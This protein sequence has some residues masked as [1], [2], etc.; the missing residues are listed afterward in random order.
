MKSGEVV[1]NLYDWNR[2]E[3]GFLGV[4]IDPTSETADVLA[5]VE[6]SPAD[7]AGIQKGD[8]IVILDGRPVRH[9]S[10]FLKRLGYFKP[11]D[12]IT[13][14]IKR[15]QSDITESLTIEL[16]RRSDFLNEPNR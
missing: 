14:E 3:R 7:R 5:V 2:R 4:Q 12:K 8:R 15:A 9:G 11:N 6:G 10:R 16:K 1:G 13:I